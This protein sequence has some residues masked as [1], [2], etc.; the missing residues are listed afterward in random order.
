MR[1]LS[2]FLSILCN[3]PNLF[4]Q[5]PQVATGRIERF[6]QFPS[7]YVTPRTVDVWLPDHY[8]PKAH[9]EV[10]Y[11]HDG[12]MLFDSTTTWN[13]Q[14]WKVDEWMDYFYGKQRLRPCIVVGI[15]NG[16]KTRHADYFPQ[17]PF[18]ALTPAQKEAIHTA[19]RSNGVSV[20]GDYEIRSDAYLKFLV[21][22]LKPFIDKRFA[23]RKGR[24][25]TFIA[26]SS[27]GGLISLY[28]LCEYPKVF[29]GAACLSTHWPGIFSMEGN[30]FPE[31]MLQYMRQHLPAPRKHRLYFDCGDQT[32]D[33]LYPPLQQ[34][35]DTV[36]RKRGFSARNWQTRF[37]P[38]DDHSEKAWSRRLDQ[39]LWFLLG[40]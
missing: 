16:G 22:E 11:M 39:P 15:W 3:A 33:A 17:K 9:Y 7:Q 37:F 14:E 19:A 18:E 36:L 26:G 25:H 27:M 12:Q 23:T 34:K 35:A 10:L 31:A 1:I 38:G 21:E 4:A 13:K 40:Q 29:G 20:F 8:D 28:A 30:P 5:L 2:I 32:L 24:R 6:E